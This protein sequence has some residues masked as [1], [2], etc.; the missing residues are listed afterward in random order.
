[1]PRAS[2][3]TVLRLAS[4]LACLACLAC[5]GAAVA[6]EIDPLELELL[7]AYE[8]LTWWDNVE[9]EPSWAGP[10]LRFSFRLGCHLARLGPGE[11]ATVKL[12]PYAALRVH[13]RD[14]R[15]RAS[16]LEASISG[17]SG[18]FR[19][20]PWREADG[21]KSLLLEPGLPAEAVARLVR[22]P[23]FSDPIEI[24]VYTSRSASP[25]PLLPYRRVLDV[26][27]PRVSLRREEEATGRTYWSLDPGA[28]VRLE[29]RGAR[30]LAIETFLRYPAGEERLTQRYML[31]FEAGARQRAL[32]F[33]TSAEMR[34]RLR[35]DGRPELLGRPRRAHLELEP[36][37]EAWISS[38][39]PLYFRVMALEERPFLLPGFHSRA[40]AGLLERQSTP[41]FLADREHCPALPWTAAAEL[42]SWARAVSGDNRLRDGSLAGG[43]ELAR[44]AAS[45]PDLQLA[46][47]IADELRLAHSMY[48]DLLPAM[49]RPG[50][51]Q[52]RACFLAEQMA[53]EIPGELLVKE[54]QVSDLLRRL[55]Q[56]LFVPLGEGLGEAN[57]YR[58]PET[59]RDSELRVAV[60]A[61]GSEADELFIETAGKLERFDLLPAAGAAGGLALGE[62]GL[63]L[64]RWQYG[65]ADAGTLGAPFAA[66]RSPAPL[67][68]AAVAELS[69]PAGAGEVRA[70]RRGR[71]Q[72]EVL[73]ALQLRV[74]KPYLLG[75]TEYLGA[76]S[77][78]EAGGGLWRRFI[79]AVQAG[80]GAP[81]PERWDEAALWNHWLPLVR[82]IEQAEAELRERVAPCER[83]QPAVLSQD[84]AAR[85]LEEARSLEGEGRWDAAL[86]AWSELLRAGGKRRFTAAQL[87]RAEALSRL[88][89][90]VLAEHLLAAML[91]H[92]PEREARQAALERLEARYRAEKETYKL[93]RLHAA[94]FRREPSHERCG[95]LAGVLLEEGEREL[96]LM[97]ALAPPPERRPAAVLL[98]AA[99]S[100]GWWRSFEAALALLERQEDM[101]FWM[102]QRSF[103]FGRRS[104]AARLLEI[105]GP[106]GRD[107][108]ESLRVAL[109]IH[110]GL[111]DG[112][113]AVRLDAIRAWEEWWSRQPGP[114]TW[115][116]EPSLIA[117]HAGGELV[118]SSSR[119]RFL[120]YFAAAAGRPLRLELRGPAAL[121]LEARAVIDIAEG[122]S[123][124]GWLELEVDGSIRRHPIARSPA[125]PSLS[126]AGETGK[127]LGR[128]VSVEMR[129]APGRHTIKLSAGE[130]RIAVRAFLGRPECSI[131]VLPEPSP[132]GVELALSG[133]LFAPR[134]P[135]YA[136]PAGD[137]VR[138]AIVPYVPGEHSPPPLRVTVP[139]ALP[140]AAELPRSP[141]VLEEYRRP[142]PGGAPSASSRL[143]E[144]IAELERLAWEAERDPE[145]SFS[146]RLRGEA[147]AETALEAPEI[148]FLRRRLAR[149]LSWE[150]LGEI[151]GGA[152]V[153]T[154]DVAPPAPES[155]ELR[156]RC[157]LMQPL[158]PGEHLIGGESRLVV[159]LSGLFPRVVRVRF[160][161]AEIEHLPPAPLAVLCRAND[162][163]VERLE[164]SAASPEASVRFA[165]DPGDHALEVWIANPALQQYVRVKLLDS[166]FPDGEESGTSRESVIER[167]LRRLYHAATADRPLVLRVKGPER[168]RIDELR[169]G[170]TS[171]SYRLVGEGWERIELRPAQGR[172]EALFRIFRRV[173][174]PA[175]EAAE[176]RELDL[177]L[178]PLP[179]AETA[180]IVLPAGSE[181]AGNRFGPG[182]D[183]DAT[184]SLSLGAERRRALDEDSRGR[185]AADEFLELRATRRSFEE[186][187]PA[188]LR[189]DIFTRVRAD[190]GPTAGASGRF[191]YLPPE[192]WQLAL[193]AEGDLYLQ[194][195]LEATFSLGGTPDWSAA[196]RGRI[197]QP[198]RLSEKL[199]HVPALSV[200]GRLLSLDGDEARR[201][202]GLDQDVFTRYKGDHQS[203]LVIS[204]AVVFRPW[205]DGRALAAVSLTTNED[206][207]PFRPDNAG[208]RLGWTQ[209]AGGL[210][211]GLEYAA[212]LFLADAH[213]RQ[214]FVRHS[215]ALRAAQDFW[216]RR[217]QRIEVGGELR[218]DLTNE[219]SS[220]RFFLAWHFSGGR[221]YRDFR[222]GELEFRDLRLQRL[223]QREEGA[224]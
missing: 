47:R 28:R 20:L 121:R 93:V 123:P 7:S 84:A 143:D 163:P 133:R 156:A 134:D 96:A 194:W 75:E 141:A 13:A 23:R 52:I 117:S 104:E 9:G 195:P 15:L 116:E 208:F 88:G 126:L 222:P 148:H 33:L 74:H 114:F 166:V 205:L 27:R 175:G 202:P 35:A 78:V 151:Q 118:Y 140:A 26:P 50:A 53:S 199:Y 187:L 91:I 24:A 218:Y 115:R 112:D 168:L 161:L 138:L 132:Q 180:G 83:R 191:T 120:E 178:A 61:A 206:F 224:P 131:R 160:T 184:W 203:G 54:E 98:R 59:W 147:L 39:A 5:R 137:G 72:G 94:A 170:R 14:G 169:D 85:L 108:A 11:A 45:R 60:V 46:R 213:R 207:N 34:R 38:S 107:Q 139:R 12:E 66:L 44:L 86:E 42:E 185:R 21:G 16:D 3:Q 18:L 171:S 63:A 87:G 146:L 193:E 19:H 97:A 209:R 220:L 164:L 82:L 100:L 211:A 217:R 129:L 212:R 76:S 150:P 43:A 127:A 68:R 221:A 162:G 215:L 58:L 17:G 77:S 210:E 70:W 186:A 177:S 56:A 8:T 153:R 128:R 152:G 106:R 71:R 155:P 200:F 144:T 32:E 142:V 105:A 36:R 158:E 135:L 10:E 99:S 4:C 102:A 157:A 69:I 29:L 48:Q 31:L 2:M 73:V 174:A 122:A 6:Q 22:P 190:G 183:E 188:Y 204:E 64:L 109:S 110:A 196:L 30:R 80:S 172:R 62:A 176:P 67:F 103:A 41:V 111:R 113:A 173:P 159:A 136:P 201:R 101:A 79:D 124:E 165:L 57:S 181:P 145:A 223:L 130:L 37:S 179:P 192:W 81:R 167:R 125:S 1:M 149:G 198:R 216:L 219:D 55:P 49:L 182:G 89:E 119:N 95:T 92:A 154:I 189:A 40:L 197:S 90:H 51:R 214:S 65:E 25:G